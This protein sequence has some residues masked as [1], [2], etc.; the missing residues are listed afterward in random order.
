MR[1]V[2][3]RDNLKEK[4]LAW[5]TVSEGFLSIM[6]ERGWQSPVHTG[7]RVQSELL[8]SPGSRE[9]NMRQRPCE[10]YNL[11]PAGQEEVG[12]W[13]NSESK[14]KHP[15]QVPLRPPRLFLKPDANSICSKSKGVF[16]IYQAT[17]PP[18]I[19]LDIYDSI[20]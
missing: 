19:P 2:P 3:D 17:M 11:K 1:A 7:G 10:T 18:V 8:T 16:L 15:F 14:G 13:F 20:Y 4:E 12:L 9:P 6:V 5:L